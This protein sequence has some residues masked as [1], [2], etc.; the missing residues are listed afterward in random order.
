MVRDRRQVRKSLR[1]CWN[2]AGL[3]MLTGTQ[4]PATLSGAD[5]EC[6]KRNGNNYLDAVGGVCRVALVTNIA[7]RMCDAATRVGGI[8]RYTP[9]LN[10]YTVTQ[11]KEHQVPTA[12]GRCI[13]LT[14]ETGRRRSQV[15]SNDSRSA[16][17]KILGTSLNTTVHQPRS[18]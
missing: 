4:Q 10:R 18:L 9:S 3:G 16:Y 6:G 14:L 5:A 7:K 2:R 11:S 15:H 1:W 17:L 13:G 12:F 8:R